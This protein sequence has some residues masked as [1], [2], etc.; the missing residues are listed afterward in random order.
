LRYRCAGLPKLKTGRLLESRHLIPS[1]FHLKGLPLV[2]A[3]KPPIL[4]HGAVRAVA[5]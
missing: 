5:A 1:G 4:A 3:R 2:A